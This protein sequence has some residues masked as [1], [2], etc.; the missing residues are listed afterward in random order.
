MN[1]IEI[2]QLL[3]VQRVYFET[4]ATLNVDK[5]LD[6]LKKLK[7]TINQF[8]P[9][10]IAAL[11]ADLNKSPTESYMCEI[12]MVYS[13]LDY[14]LKHTRQFAKKRRVRTP[15]AQAIATSY[16]LPSPFGVTLILSPWNY[17]FMLS[18]DPLIDALSAGNT[19][20]IKPS[21]Y[22]PN[23]S[24]IIKKII[25][26]TFPREL[27]A[28]IEGGRAENTALLAQNF[29]Y[30]FFTGSKNVGKE[31]LRQAASHLTP[32]TLE[33]GGKSPCIVDQSA[34]LK[35]AAKRIIFG[36]FL[37]AGQT[38][39]APDYLLCHKTKVSELLSLLKQEIKV[40][41]GNN[42]LNNPDL[43][44]IIN[45][46]HFNRLNDLLSASQIYEGGQTN[47]ETLQIAPT[48]IYP[49]AKDAKVMQ[50]EIF[51]PLL[52]IITYEDLNEVIKEVNQ[53]E[54]PLALY[55]F[56]SDQ[57]TI[58]YVLSHAHFGG[59]SINETIMHLATPYMGFGGL[60][61]SGMGAYHG[62]TGFDTFTHYKSVIAKKTWF[63]LSV[64]YQPY[65]KFKDQII[66][67]F[68]H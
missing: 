2:K 26:E 61:E 56:A 39:V 31:V 29:D 21:A 8:E 32:V 13:E 59:A 53:G 3:D 37:N 57:K 1:E 45:Q 6:H 5:R 14:M 47:S 60:K 52:P 11:K 10:I 54:T 17:P 34:D 23:T 66:K 64:R 22:A 12:G 41:Y 35:M 24:H 62:K 65:T 68:M 36:K 40:Q 48:I 9:E 43:C 67:F 28:V 19:V 18:I 33:L 38:C 44:K 63:D 30:I 50:E 55:F 15:L 42:P 46:K 27:V 25:E 20:I 51:G 7:K 16:V 49:C 58:D 4:G